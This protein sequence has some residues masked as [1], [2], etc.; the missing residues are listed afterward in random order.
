MTV[1]VQGAGE[2]G[3]RRDAATASAA[4]PPFEVVGRTRGVRT[5]SRGPQPGPSTLTI[6]GRG[7]PG[8][9]TRLV[10]GAMQRAV[11]R[12]GRDRAALFSSL[13]VGPQGVVRTGD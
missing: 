8:Y 11:T 12:Q 1:G 10:T 9:G 5:S 2:R 13:R 3:E 7:I 6:E 4:A